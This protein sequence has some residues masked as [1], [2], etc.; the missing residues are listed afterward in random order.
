MNT[1]FQSIRVGIFFV[2]G[3]LLIYA[4][5]S[6]IGSRPVSGED[7]VNI[8]AEFDDIR[9]LSPG[10]AVRMAGVRIG[11]V[12]ATELAEGRGRVTLSVNPEVKI[13]S[14]SVARIN[15]AS[16]LGQNYVSVEYGS[17]SDLLGDGDTISAEAGPDLNEILGEVQ[18]LGERLNQVADSFSGMGDTG[19]GELFTNLNELVTDNRGRFDNVLANLETLTTKLN[20]SEGTLGKLINEDGMYS[21]LMSVI[22]ELRNASGDMEEALAGARDVIARV[23]AG[24]G[25]LGKLL[26]DDTIAKNLETTMLNFRDFSDKLNSG[27]GTLGK[28][29]T[30]DSLY[31]ELQSMLN[32]AD[33]AL[34]SMGDAGPITAAGAVSNAL[35]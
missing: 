15:M 14:D 35:F 2:L 16:L 23:Q 29:V 28:L 21:E 31:I 17:A 27:E 22:G 20:R 11:E 5:Y 30:D 33:R 3:I 9:T 26:A 24:E 10:A 19:M 8:I 13:P 1:T 34:D 25:T 7:A 4:V 6:V 18:Q 12:A 32:K